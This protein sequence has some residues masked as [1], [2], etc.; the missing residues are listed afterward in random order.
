LEALRA[1]PGN[2]RAFLGEPITELD[3]GG[4]QI[5][6]LPFDAA[7]AGALTGGAPE[8]VPNIRIDPASVRLYAMMRTARFRCGS[9][10]L[11]SIPV[12]AR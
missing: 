11:A 12:R 10:Y 2:R 6:I 4:A 1:P 8:A 7:V 3:R 5:P 9:P